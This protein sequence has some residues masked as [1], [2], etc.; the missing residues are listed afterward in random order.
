M[1][2][3]TKTK[4]VCQKIYEEDPKLLTSPQFIPD[5]YFNDWVTAEDFLLPKESSV[6]ELF[7]HC[8][9]SDYLIFLNGSIWSDKEDDHVLNA[10]LLCQVLSGN[11]P[12]LKLFKDCSG[13]A[14]PVNTDGGFKY[15]DF[16]ELKWS[17][18]ACDLSSLQSYK[19]LHLKPDVL[20]NL[21][22]AIVD[23][24]PQQ[25]SVYKER[26][27]KTLFK[28]PDN[29]RLW[30][31]IETSFCPCYFEDIITLYSICNE[32][33]LQKKEDPLSRRDGYSGTVLYGGG[34]KPQI[35]VGH[36][37][38]QTVFHRS[39]TEAERIQDGISLGCEEGNAAS[40]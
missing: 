25:T 24:Y 6:L 1:K 37:S 13:A 27:N 11:Y 2:I 7:G 32:D 34:H 18:K 30:F 19:W 33:R 21:L 16:P 20:E 8:F 4:E 23:K 15:G 17:K 39:P 3:Y 5:I 22:K 29:G 12:N 9:Y 14:F 26:I 31:D 10:A 36:L 28:H 38:N 35:T 40:D